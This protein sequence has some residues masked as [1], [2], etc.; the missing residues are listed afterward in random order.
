M[1]NKNP[2]FIE[3]PVVAQKLLSLRIKHTRVAEVMNELHTLIYPS[4]QDSILL[5]CGPSGVGKSTLA[6][7]M[8]DAANEAAAAR[9]EADAGFMP[10]VYVEASGHVPLDGLPTVLPSGRAVAYGH[11][12][13]NRLVLLGGQ[14]APALFVF[15]SDRADYDRHDADSQR[16]FLAAA[17]ADGGW[18]T[19]AAIEAA[20]AAPDFY[21]D[22]LTRTR[23]QAFTRGR[24]ALVSE[25]RVSQLHSQALARLRARFG[26]G[27]V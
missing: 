3:V 2:L 22:A 14:K 24:L 20:L 8:V 25:S 17:F 21:L 10:A 27:T 1:S 13:P 23:M 5:V 15:R 6:E 11:N 19:P 26:G 9:M 4:S 12:R 18:R 7:H 16:A